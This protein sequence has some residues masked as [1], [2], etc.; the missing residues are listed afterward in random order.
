MSLAGNQLTGNIRDTF[1]SFLDL[2][3]IDFSENQFTGAIPTRLFDLQSIL[4]IDL[5]SNELDGRIPENIG[6]AASLE[7]LSLHENA[8]TGEVP[9]ID[10]GELT[11]LKVFFVHSN[12]LTGSMDQSVCELRVV[13][14]GVLETLWTDCGETADPRIECDNPDCCTMCFPAELARTS[15]ASG[16]RGSN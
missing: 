14:F 9:S 3:L 13:G 11:N 8:L 10:S 12:R 4:K 16:L 2:E 1:S 7:I 5:H 6:N 15:D